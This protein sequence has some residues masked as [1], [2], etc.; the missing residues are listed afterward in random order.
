MMTDPIA[1]MLTRIRNACMVRKPQVS[2]PYSKVKFAIAK[3]ME[4]VGYIMNV[5]KHDGPKP[6]MTITLKYHEKRPHIT[7]IQRISKPGLRVYVKSDEI[8]KVHGGYGTA[9][10]STSRGIM[11]DDQ[12]RSE[13]VGG[14][15]LCTLY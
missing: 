15:I 2:L 9:M 8:P 11:T 5:E 3:K 7:E 4:E 14:E 12:A 13:G 10:L 6:T 1:D